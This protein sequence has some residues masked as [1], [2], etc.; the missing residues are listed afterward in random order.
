MWQLGRDETI[1]LPLGRRPLV[2]RLERGSVIVT[3]TGDPEDHVLGAGEEVRLARHGLT[4]AWA[5]EPSV[6]VLEDSGGT[7]V[8]HP[9]EAAA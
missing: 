7:L 4:V 9:L 3:Q 1:R 2:A 5:L 6:L 8:H